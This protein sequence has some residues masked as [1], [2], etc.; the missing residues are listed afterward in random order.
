MNEYQKLGHMSKLSDAEIANTGYYIPHQILEKPSS[1]TTKF[2][3]VFNESCADISSTSLNDH[4]MIG[5]TLQ[6]E[7]FDTIVRFRNHRIAF[8]AEIEKMYRQ[9]LVHP[10]DRR[11]QRILHRCDPNEKK[12]F[13]E[14]ILF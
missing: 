3:V 5:L 6:P 1:T 4:L 10:T 11:Y 14:I 2:R 12:I 7:L 9:I 13:C 8:C